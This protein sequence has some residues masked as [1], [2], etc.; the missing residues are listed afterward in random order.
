MGQP[1]APLP[2]ITTSLL[3][4]RE[5]GYLAWV[6]VAHEIAHLPLES[7][8]IDAS[9]HAL[10]IHVDG[11][12]EPLV[13]IAEPMGPP[14]EQGFP[15]LLRPLDEHHEQMLRAELFGGEPPPP[16]TKPA[17]S[18]KI[19]QVTPASGFTPAQRGRPQSTIPPPLTEGHAMA[20]GRMTNPSTLARRAP[21]ALAGRTLGDGRFQLEDLIG[22][23][24]SGEVYRGIHT[25]LRRRVAVKVLHPSLQQS[26]D[27]CARFYAEA[28][29]ASRLDH[30]NVLRVI[31]YGQEPEGLLYIV[32]ELLEGLS[33]QQILDN[34]GPMPLTRIVHFVSQA[35]AGLAN[36]H[37]AGVIHRDIKP[38]NIVVVKR[39][40]DDGRE[41][42]LVKVCDFGIAHWTPVSPTSIDDD[43]ATLVMAPD[44]SKIVGTPVY[45][46][47]EQIRN[48]EVDAR[49]D[50]Y[51][52]GIVLY[53]L[54]TGR[55]PF[56]SENP[57]DILTQHLLEP[58]TPPSKIVRG[59]D[60]KLER[61]ILKALSKD[62]ER[63]QRDVRELRAELM[64]LVAE[65]WIAGSGLH[66]RVSVK[67]TL[68][69]QD[70]LTNTAESL[71]ILHGLD[72]RARSIGYNALAEAI[73]MAVTS[74]NAR[75]ARDLVGWLEARLKDPTLSADERELGERAMHV[76]R[77]ADVARAHA[78]GLLDN[79]VER[80][81][82]S[83]GMLRTAG[84]VAARALI[85]ARR[86]RPP[87][88]EQRGQ[89]VAVLRL[90]GP[91]ALPAII[92][93]LEPLAHL[94]TR[95]DEA[96]AEDLL[97]ALPD[98]RS[99]PAGDATVRF[100][101]LDK[102]SLGMAALKATAMLWGARARPLLVGVL[103]AQSDA[104]RSLA[105]EELQRLGCIDDLAVERL[106]RIIV[107]QTPAS[108]ELRLAAAN[109]I[110]FATP[111]ARP[112]ALAFLT[113]KLVPQQGFMSSILSAL[114]QQ[115]EDVRIDLALARSLLQLDPQGARTTLERLVQARPELR[116]QVEGMLA[117]R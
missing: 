47:P 7:P 15:L 57:L 41:T 48:E 104:F 71:G 61:I 103:D 114:G 117:G 110:R 33:L 93:A 92:A 36:A 34:E 17:A 32:M 6:A 115:R 101:R 5:R 54:S 24:A 22:G 98:V 23:G 70:F 66:R 65:E 109:A 59:V 82:E 42:D 1:T 56:L 28:L 116:M 13:V 91:A 12:A 10:E 45:M 69:A 67:T 100:V 78:V 86:V 76:L 107:V 62:P 73:R 49:T 8:P 99:D 94:A 108:T 51:A 84:P 63:R 60:P 18:P 3:E 21:G 31:D 46:A 9:P 80:S 112:R 44:P 39:R 81:E 4:R 95:H 105:I 64:A 55:V 102:P 83:I 2:V 40:D 43:A 50:V 30:R 97:R 27:Y 75:L 85:D 29:A 19:T 20:L 74:G 90:V 113:Q 53:E 72:E 35:C 68:V 106:A 87:S 96:L 79:K 26:Q 77:D 89:F 52:L 14:G 88:L 16:S 37:D 111:E 11:Y 38:E 58:P 25:A